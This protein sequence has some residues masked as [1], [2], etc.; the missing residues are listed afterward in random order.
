MI[1]NKSIAVPLGAIKQWYSKYFGKNT[2]IET[3]SPNYDF[4]TSRN[5]ELTIACFP[6]Y[7]RDNIFK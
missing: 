5:A 2:Y 7:Y 1:H 4:K 3:A 6:I